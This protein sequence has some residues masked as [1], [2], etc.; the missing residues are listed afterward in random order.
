M[1]S[2]LLQVGRLPVVVLVVANITYLLRGVGFVHLEGQLPELIAVLAG[3]VAG[4][5]GRVVSG[6][7][8]VHLAQR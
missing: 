6:C 2:S 7:F 4:L 1:A 8:H 3:Y 5:L